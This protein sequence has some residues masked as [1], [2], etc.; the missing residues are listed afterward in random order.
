MHWRQNSE[1]TIVFKH[2]KERVAFSGLHSLCRGNGPS[3]ELSPLGNVSFSLA[4]L[5]M[6]LS[7]QQLMLYLGLDFFGLRLS[8]P[9]RLS[10]I[11]S[12]TFCS[13]MLSLLIRRLLGHDPGIFLCCSNWMIC[14]DLGLSLVLSCHL[15]S[16]FNELLK[17]LVTY[18]PVS[19]FSFGSSTT[20]FFTDN[21][22][23]T[24]LSMFFKHFTY[25]L[26]WVRER[27][28]NAPEPGEGK[29]SRFPA[30]HGA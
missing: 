3:F 23:F 24:F 10:A 13:I 30:E 25:L 18:F 14:I 21:S 5:K 26:E 28:E 2:F 16:L 6:S 22:L 12:V 8:F 20:Y 7:F 27:G 19:I 9:G 29:R 17:I 4:A 11:I 1:L 15:L